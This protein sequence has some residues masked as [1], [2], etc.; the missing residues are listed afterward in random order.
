MTVADASNLAYRPKEI[1]R[2]ALACPADARKLHLTHPSTTVLT[3]FTDTI[4]S[5]R[6]MEQN[7]LKEQ[8]EAV[9]ARLGSLDGMYNWDPETTVI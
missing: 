7:L 2:T 8:F 3:D 4:A 5:L 9:V 6:S 1:E